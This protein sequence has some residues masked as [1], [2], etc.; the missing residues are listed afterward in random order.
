[1]G[2]ISTVSLRRPEPA[3]A[4]VPVDVVGVRA[5]GHDRRYVRHHF[6]LHSLQLL[7][8]TEQRRRS[9]G[10]ISDN[11]ASNKRGH[12]GFVFTEGSMKIP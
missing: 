4:N 12:S 9:G 8:P 1:M 3:S 6:E 7:P 2:D 10:R 11:R 5:Y